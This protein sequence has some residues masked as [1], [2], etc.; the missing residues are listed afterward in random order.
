MD[1]KLEDWIR[2]LLSVCDVVCMFCGITHYHVMCWAALL[3]A[4]LSLDVDILGTCV[5][6]VACWNL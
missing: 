5:Y 6:I 3:E 2:N 1:Q 4:E